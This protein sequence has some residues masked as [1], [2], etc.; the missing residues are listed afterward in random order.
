[1]GPAPHRVRSRRGRIAVLALVVTSAVAV[2]GGQVADGSRSHRSKP[3]R[4]RRPVAA[5]PVAARVAPLE[6][7][8]RI[9]RYTD[10]APMLGRPGAS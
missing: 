7:R 4:L 10:T 2:A 5:H 3:Q 8:G 9:G 6:L 1:M